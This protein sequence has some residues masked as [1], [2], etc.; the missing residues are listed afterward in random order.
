VAQ[1]L[2]STFPQA[3]ALIYSRGWPELLLKRHFKLDAPQ[4]ENGTKEASSHAEDV[5]GIPILYYLVLV[6]H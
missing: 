5:S 6:D 3:E 2:M 1:E 4:D